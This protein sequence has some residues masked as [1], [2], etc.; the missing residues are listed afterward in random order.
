MARSSGWSTPSN[1]Q[2]NPPNFPPPT[3]SVTL[4]VCSVHTSCAG[5]CSSWSRAA[6][7]LR[8]RIGILPPAL[9]EAAGFD[10]PVGQPWSTTSSTSFLRCAAARAFEN[11]AQPAFF[12]HST[13]H[14]RPR[15]CLS[16]ALL[17]AA[18][19]CVWPAA[20]RACARW[21]GACVWAVGERRVGVR[22]VGG[23][24]TRATATALTVTVSQWLAVSDARLLSRAMDGS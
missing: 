5:R 22:G 21:S 4:T 17:V 12:P 24:C 14:A 6:A 1:P 18:C 15:F 16:G 20:A 2:S 8:P 9:L 10:S 7:K 11:S 23:R 13:P 19:V 3:P